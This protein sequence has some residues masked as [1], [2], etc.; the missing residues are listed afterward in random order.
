MFLN[1]YPYTDFHEMNLDFL[2]QSMDAL[3]KAFKD[4]TASNSLI[5]AEPLQ[6]D[7][8]E[9]YA[10]NTIV[11]DP[12]GNAYISLQEVPEGIQ[13]SNA[14]Y[15]LMVFNFEDYTEKA[16]KNFTVNYFRDTTRAPYALSVGDWVVLNDVLYTVTQAIAADELFV[17]GTNLTHFTVEQ[18]LKDF[19]TSIVQTVNQY[20]NDIDASELAY[21]N[22]IDASEAAF[23]SGLQAQFEQVIAGVTVD[24]E[25]INARV[26]VNGENYANLGVAIR[27]QLTNEAAS[28][29]DDIVGLISQYTD[30]DQV[31]SYGSNSGSAVS[32]YGIWGFHFYLA[33][34]KAIG[35]TPRFSDGSNDVTNGTYELVKVSVDGNGD[36]DK[37][38]SRSI[39]KIGEEIVI[40]NPDLKY[41]YFLN[42]PVSD[43]N[44]TLRPKYTGTLS[45]DANMFGLGLSQITTTLDVGEA[46]T[47][48]DVNMIAGI[49]KL[50][51][52]IPIVDSAI[53]GKTSENYTIT[54]QLRT[55]AYTYWGM[56]FNDDFYEFDFHPYFFDAS[57]QYVN[58]GVYS[59]IRGHLDDA[60]V[61]TELHTPFSANIG[62]D[63]PLFNVNKN[64][65][66]L[67]ISTP[68]A[69][70]RLAYSSGYSDENSMMVAIAASVSNLAIGVTYSP[71]DLGIIGGAHKFV[72]L[73]YRNSPLRGKR[74]TLIG[75]SITNAGIGNSTARVGWPER[76]RRWTGCIVQN[77]AQ[78]GSNWH[79]SHDYIDK[80]PLI[81]TPDIIGIAASFNGLG[82]TPVGTVDDGAGSGTMCGYCNEFI[83][84]LLSSYPTT[85][86]IVYSQGPWKD[87]R[88]AY[89][90]SVTDYLEK[91]KEICNRFGVSFY[92][93][94]FFN[95]SPLRPWTVAN[96]TTYY[97]LD[98]DSGV[99]PND[100]GHLIIARR[101]LP[102]FEE[103]IIN[104]Y[105]NTPLI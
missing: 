105:L 3:K 35:F 32:V 72:K 46:V 49:V 104:E 65:F 29:D 8:T 38:I 39:H 30:E 43:N 24:S 91:V 82:N 96:Q 60:G 74:V 34:D 2:L 94:L 100:A 80:I 41:H 71:Y 10:K 83:G 101:L 51:P 45:T 88:Y 95:G 14:D 54:P 58:S 17:V 67:V 64:D 36:I 52:D 15:W 9:S 11:L 57:N 99:H 44:Q 78:D 48:T 4:F 13:L 7:L 23:V 70:T 50:Y 79:A 19:T 77:L 42:H 22:D 37:I 21:K 86:I 103:N 26:G 18:F 63:V 68:D 102:K 85:P 40:L 97:S 53:L 62:A 6:H 81:D 27:T 5:F 66:I 16:N 31:S 75:D 89:N 25:V 20:K 73:S 59:M 28:S 47:S 56:L 98:P 1:G 92:G 12:D 76:I 33:T 61:V 93:D 87:C 55:G 84:T 69:N 90:A